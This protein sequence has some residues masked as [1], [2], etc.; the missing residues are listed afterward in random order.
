MMRLCVGA[1][2]RRVV[3][4]AARLRVC[5]VVASR[6]QA[7]EFTPG[8]TGHTSATLVQA[9]KDLSGGAT[10]VVRDHGGP[11]QNGDE[12]DDWT[13]AF[14]A[15]VDAG[16]D[17]LHLDVSLL[18]RGEQPAELARLCRRYGGRIAVEVGGERDPQEH[19]G[20]LL[21]TALQHLPARRGGSRARRAHPR[22]PA[23]R[24]PDRRRRSPGGR[25]GV[26]RGAGESAQSRLAG[27]PAVL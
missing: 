21:E 26:R 10:L 27:R 23:A 4:E 25:R 15:D 1:A 9:V 19:L 20:M 8:Y 6:R 5:Q 22:R 11:Y 7:G 3:E 16:F 17:V 13:A 14:D 18:P 24:A 2:S 12:D